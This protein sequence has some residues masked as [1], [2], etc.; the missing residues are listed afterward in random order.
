MGDHCRQFAKHLGK[1]RLYE[2]T[3]TT[4]HPQKLR[5]CSLLRGSSLYRGQ[6][7]RSSCTMQ[8]AGKLSASTCSMSEL[9]LA[10]RYRQEGGISDV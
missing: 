1:R 10:L 9:R 6:E 3:T 8:S 4:Q 2:R 7:T 5:Q